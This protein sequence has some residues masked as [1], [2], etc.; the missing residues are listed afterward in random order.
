MFVKVTVLAFLLITNLISEIYKGCGESEKVARDELAKSI[1]VSVASEFERV[2]EVD[3]NKNRK[4]IKNISKQSTKLKLINIKI[5]NITDNKVCATITKYD[6]E[7]SLK[8]LVTEVNSFNI[9]ELPKEPVK[10]KEEL[11]QVIENCESGIKLASVLGYQR[12]IANL[13]H[14]LQTFKSRLETIYTQFVRFNLGDKNLKIYIDGKKHWYRINEDIPLKIGEHLYTIKSRSHCEIKGSFS[15]SED[16]L[17]IIDDID[18]EDYLYPKITWT[19]NKEKNFISLEVGGENRGIN[20]EQV[21]KKC[22]GEIVYRAE[23]KDGDFQDVEAGKV[24]LKPGLNKIIHLEFLSIGDIKAIQKEAKPY[25]SGDRL[26]ILYSYGHVSQ[27]SHYWKDTHN[28]T[29]QKLTHKRFFRYGYGAL[30]GVDDLN[31]HDMMVAELYYAFAVQFTSFGDN[32]L[33]LRIG[34]FSFIPYGGINVG[35]GYHEYKYN[36]K[37]I[38]SYPREG[39]DD[40][41]KLP[42]DYDW[43]FKRD[44]F[45]L[46]PVLGV[47]IILSRGFA[48]KFYGEKDIYIDTRWFFGTGLSIEF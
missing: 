40:A 28:I 18:V 48:L 37:K 20:Q 4:E 30:Y 46:K 43:N 42:P 26:E 17:K 44:F 32:D 31:S 35:I 25:I 15:V 23:Y 11:K 16:E 33:P 2:D 27:D 13:S 1:Y 19:S 22:S 12:D 39:D 5:E 10:A 8:S 3:E 24:K 9:K 7:Q 34:K 6:L 41:E 38:Y 21:I 47:D 29:I 14:K 36:G 45:V